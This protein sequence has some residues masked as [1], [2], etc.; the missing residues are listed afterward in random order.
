M[1]QK[2]VT[3]DVT[4]YTGVA[5]IL[6]GTVYQDDDSLWKFSNFENGGSASFHDTREQ[7]EAVA[8]RAY[9]LE[10]NSAGLV[11]WR[12][13]RQEPGYEEAKAIVVAAEDE[14]T[15]RLFAVRIAIDS[16]L[17]GSSESDF[18]LPERSTITPIGLAL[19]GAKPGDM[20]L[21]A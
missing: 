7:A 8:D 14:H 2:N 21:V 17:F 4:N 20:L 15:A 3:D 12:L 18:A 5:G 6:L 13:I 11:L 16:S 19:K 9:Q 10:E 1:A